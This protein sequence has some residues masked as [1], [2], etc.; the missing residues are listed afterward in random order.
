MA[1]ALTTNDQWKA[2]IMV[3]ALDP[4]VVSVLWQ[5]IYHHLPEHIYDHPLGCHR[6]RVPDL[7][8]FRGILI[9]LTTGLSWE[10]VEALMEFKVS[11]TTLRNRRDEG[12]QSVDEVSDRINNVVVTR[13]LEL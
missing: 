9:R 11:D 7:L 5:A 2:L 12:V 1:S 8:C 6:K 13:S 3:R 10:D 4:A